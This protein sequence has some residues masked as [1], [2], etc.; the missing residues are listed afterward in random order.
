TA[1]VCHVELTTPSRQSV[2]SLHD[3]HTI[4][5]SVTGMVSCPQQGS[6]GMRGL[7]R[8]CPE[9]SQGILQLPFCPEAQMS[10]AGNIDLA[11]DT[12]IRSEV[13]T[14]ELKS[15][16]DLDCSILHQNI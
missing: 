11:S 10:C 15:L 14:S 5:G 12:G 9:Q 3:A 1:S 4:S 16:F 8:R 6:A 7:C 2:I 13:I